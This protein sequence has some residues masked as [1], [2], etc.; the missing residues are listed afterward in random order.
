MDKK[1]KSNADATEI[2]KAHYNKYEDRKNF[3]PVQKAQ[4]SITVRNE[5]DKLDYYGYRPSETLPQDINEIM[6]RCEEEYKS[7]GILRSIVDLITDFIVDGLTLVHPD[8][9]LQ[10]FYNIWAR[11]VSLQD[12]ASQ[13]VKNLYRS[14][15]VV[16]RRH[17][18]DINSKTFNQWKQNLAVAASSEDTTNY[19]AV[20]KNDPASIPVK[21]VFYRPS[22]IYLVGNI[23]GALSDKKIYGMKIS[24]KFL[25]DLRTAKSE[26]EKTVLDALP[27]DIKDAIDKNSNSPYIMWPLK[28]DDIYV[29]HYCKDDYDIWATPLIYS[30][31]DDINYNKKLKQ[32]K[33][34][35]LDNWYNAIRIWKLGDHTLDVWPE[36][37][38]GDRLNEILTK[39]TGGGGIDLIWDSAIQYEEHYPPVEKLKDFVE[40]K[41]PIMS[42][43]GIPQEITGGF[44]D[45]GTAGNGALRLKTFAKKLAAGRQE[46]RKWLEFELDI[47]SRNMKIPEKPYVKFRN[48]DSMDER[49]YY[50]L[51]RELVD[52]GILSDQTM[53]EKLN[54]IPQIEQQRVEQEAKMRESG[55]LPPK[56]SPFNNP[57]LEKQ[58]EMDIMIQKNLPNEVKKKPNDKKGGRPAGVKDGVP[59]KRGANK[60]KAELLAFASDA[61][62]KI[63][64]IVTDLVLNQYNAQD[65]RSLNKGQ[66]EQLDDLRSFTLANIDPDLE[67]SEDN[68]VRAMDFDPS[69]CEQYNTIYSNLLKEIPSESLSAAQRHSLKIEAYSILF[70]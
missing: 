15:N 28:N 14:C 70:E 5:F 37:I 9:N 65:V 33:T 31:L 7:T 69:L 57:N 11:K 67:L 23:A 61:Y 29:G 19:N 46:L 40:D 25:T 47:I 12:K 55:K 43:F 45:N 44:M 52:R 4:A 51:L 6:F 13:F 62:T 32:A 24:S 64:N 21:Y 50:T 16:V 66:K 48:D 8:P 59:R 63:D 34:A 10:N 30:I 38:A 27:Q 1:I 20:P 54:E 68:I 2:V 18:V 36:T 17:M 3:R 26:L 49:V 41:D 60:N 53:L 35:G 42:C 56:A 39:N 22:S 58:A